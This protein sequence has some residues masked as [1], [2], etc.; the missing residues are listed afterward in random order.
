MFRG[1]RAGVPKPAP[2]SLEDLD[3]VQRV[4]MQRSVVDRPGLPGA[5]QKTPRPKLQRHCPGKDSDGGSP[6][7]EPVD[8]GQAGRLGDPR[9]QLASGGRIGGA[10]KTLPLSERR[11]R[12]GRPCQGRA[13]RATPW[14][15][16]KDEKEESEVP[17]VW[18]RP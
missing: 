1:G 6:T 8:S 16:A 18:G 7:P 10:E 15:Q 12:F 17:R 5:R 9:G 2:R 4:L 14:T 3:S 11:R 13:G